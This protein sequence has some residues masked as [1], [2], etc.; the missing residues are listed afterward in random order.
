MIS[1]DI[2]DFIEEGQS[3]YVGTCDRLLRPEGARAIAALVAPD[4]ASLTCFIP[5]VAARRVLP[6]LEGGGHM[7]IVFV[8]PND[9]HAYQVKGTFVSSRPAADDEREPVAAQ[10]IGFQ[11]KLESIGVSRR[12]VGTWPYWPCVAVRMRVTAVF[13][14]TPG[15]GAGAPLS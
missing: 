8:R 1:R 14:Q 13:N 5:E 12:L 9:D 4:R 2:A 10:W 7:A 3:I 11:D 15:P 6:N